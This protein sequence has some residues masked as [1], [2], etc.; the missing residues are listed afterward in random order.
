MIRLTVNGTKHYKSLKTKKDQKDFLEEMMNQISNSIPVDRSRLDCLNHFLEY[1]KSD[2]D[3]LLFITFKIDHSNGNGF[4]SKSAKD[5]FNDFVK[6]FNI[7]D[8]IKTNLD[9]NSHA[10]YIDKKFKPRETCKYCY[11][12]IHFSMNLLFII[13]DFFFK[14]PIYGKKSK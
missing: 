7:S 14:Q 13:S 10:Q 6:L 2:R 9:I 5:V 4:N 3:D 8:S 11:M 1:D 12:Y